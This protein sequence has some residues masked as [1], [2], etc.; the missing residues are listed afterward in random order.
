MYTYFKT[1][2][3]VIG[4]QRVN[5]IS[6]LREAVKE[7][8]LDELK[9]D[10]EEIDRLGEYEVHRKDSED[11]DKVYIKFQNE[12]ASN[13]ITRK[14]AMVKNENVNIFPF[15]PPQMYQRFADLSRFTYYARHADKSLKT[16]I[17]LGK[18][19][20]VLKTKIKDKTD[21]IVQDDLH[22]FGVLSEV[23]MNVLWP[24]M[25]VKQITSPPKGRKRKN[26]HDMSMNSDAESPYKKRPKSAQSPDVLDDPE[27]NKKVAEF[28]MNLE[29][30][31]G[32]RKF[33]QTKIK[34]A[35]L[36][37]SNK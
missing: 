18:R 31:N 1:Y 26:V 29:K 8:L 21:W 7:F 9:L 19:D 6:A 25:E 15:I 20:L 14:A 35:S 34:F 37:D 32:N 2:I 28:V 30:K 17:T 36:K 24:V 11:N 5:G 23:D 13:Y 16:K 22:V 27:K 4:S 33:S 12:E 10:D 3:Y